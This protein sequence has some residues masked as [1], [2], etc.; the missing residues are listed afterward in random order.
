MRTGGGTYL[1]HR[2]DGG[3]GLVTKDG[4]DYGFR[5]LTRADHLDYEGGRLRF[6]RQRLG[7]WT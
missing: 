7:G 3:L 5:I 4:T 1:V 6:V 2:V